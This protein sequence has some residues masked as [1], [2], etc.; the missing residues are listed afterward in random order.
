ME[1]TEVVWWFEM[2]DDAT[3]IAIHPFIQTNQFPTRTNG[4]YTTT[5]MLHTELSCDFGIF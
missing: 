3:E 1:M 2:T 4:P 5:V